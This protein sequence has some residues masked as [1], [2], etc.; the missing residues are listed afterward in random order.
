MKFKAIVS[1][2]A[3][4]EKVKIND[5][6][7]DVVLDNRDE[8]LYKVKLKASN[9]AGIKEYNFSEVILNNQKNIDVNF[10]SKIEVLKAKPTLENYIVN[11]DPI[12]SKA[13]ISF[14]LVDNDKA[15]TSGEVE[16]LDENGSLVK[17]SDVKKGNNEFTVTI[18][19]NK[20]YNV[21][22]DINYNLTSKED[23]TDTNYVN[24]L[25]F[26]KELQIIED[27]KFNI[28]NYQIYNENVETNNFAK[29]EEIKI[30]FDS[31]NVSKYIPDFV[32]INGK[33]YKLTLEN[34]KYTVIVPGFD[35]IGNNNLKIE[36]V[37]LD[38]GKQFEINKNFVISVLKKAPKISDFM[39]EENENGDI[40]INFN[41]E[42][43][44][45]AL[46]SMIINITDEKDI[47][48][49]QVKLTNDELKGSKKISKK[50]NNLTNKSKYKISI[51]A[52]YLLTNDEKDIQKNVILYQNEFLAQFRAN[53]L[54]V[55]SDKNYYEK[56]DK[57]VLTYKIETNCSH[58]IAK[59][60]INNKEYIAT[61]VGEGIYQVDYTVSTNRGIYDISTSKV[62]CSS[63]NV[64]NVSNNM[65]LEV[66][67]DVLTLEDFKEE[68]NTS[69][70]KVNISFNIRDID[71]SFVA[72]KILLTKKNGEVKYSKDINIGKNTFTLDLESFTT[73]DLKINVTYDRDSKNDSF[74]KINK[75]LILK[76][77]EGSKDYKLVVSNLKT[78][79]NN[80]ETKYFAKN[81]KINLVF[82]SENSR[83]L[84]I[85]KVTI[86]GKKYAVTK[87]NNNYQVLVDGFSDALEKTLILEK[88][89]LS[90]SV[91]LSVKE[92]NNIKIEIL[93]DI[94]TVSDFKYTIDAN[95]SKVK[96]EFNL[97]D[98]DSSLINTQVILVDNKGDVV[99]RKDIVK[100]K[101]ALEF[102]IKRAVLYT[103]KV[104][105]SYDRDS[106][107]DST[108]NYQN[109]TIFTKEIIDTTDYSVTITDIKA[110]KN[111]VESNYFAKNENINLT[112]SCENASHLDTTEVTINGK[113]YAVT[114]N[115]NLYHVLV[116]GFNDAGSKAI[117]IE[118]VKLS[119]NIEIYVMNNNTI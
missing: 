82:E 59:L 41:T 116:D 10:V 68:F 48:L 92:N 30:T 43:E 51:V 23:L 98:T 40:D 3:V 49:K 29:N 118:K 63:G 77:I 18:V 78:T 50:I 31:S 104:N 114:K 26:S 70:S 100:G 73:Y 117:N 4:I 36:S 39:F 106:K 101:T 64:A 65:K 8:N 89:K 46:I 17:K 94:P 38:N 79:K 5:E 85:E 71:N 66:L 105:A 86:D 53:I 74:N 25:E 113:K 2:D 111:D 109:K 33:N 115:N 1:Y 22:F 37:I 21:N 14:N 67:K 27:Y 20:I 16:V 80:K 60:R 88:V 42:N 9:T 61:K 91:E 15:M 119:N 35:S 107:V 6:Y 45:D 44:D 13:I 19:N 93:K 72:G 54:E 76:E 57:A 90:N 102:N 96:V 24:K 52:N 28:G 55:T 7:Y 112:F 83:N 47:L 11:D 58:E 69:K 32:K 34:N 84:D 97:N 108:N 81:E 75:D 87:N 62:V 110:L 95:N 99:S 12:N 103:L 56:G